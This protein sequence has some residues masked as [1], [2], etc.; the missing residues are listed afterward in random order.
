MDKTPMG[1][2]RVWRG[3]MP[4]QFLYTAGVAGERF[5]DTLRTRGRLAVTRCADCLVTYLPP[6]IYCERCFADLSE[7]WAEVAPTGRVHTFTVA[8]FGQDGC[9]LEHPDI[10]ACVRIDGTDGGLLGRLLHMRAQ[11]VRLE[12]PV[13]AVLLPARRRRGTIADIAGFAPRRELPP[14][15]TRR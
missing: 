11:D 8:H 3:E 4:V 1:P 5:F 14:A 13:E 12:M 15:R 10:V 7:T 6:R 9:P 2:S